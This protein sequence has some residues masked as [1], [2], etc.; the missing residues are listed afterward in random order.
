ME[1][2]VASIA[3]ELELCKRMLVE[4]IRSDIGLIDRIAQHLVLMKGKL[5]RPKL[6]LLSA[7]ACGELDGKAISVA[8]AVELVHTGALIH[9]DV[10]DSSQFRRGM[11]SVN[12]RW[13]DHISVLMGDY[14]FSKAFSMLVDL[15]CQQLLKI[16]SRTTQRMSCGEMLQVELTSNLEVGEGDYLRMI[17]DKTA[18]LISAAC[19]MGAVLGTDRANVREHLARFGENLGYAY[20]I[21]DDL[22]DFVGVE[23]LTG[24][25]VGSDIRGKKITLPLIYALNSAPPTKSNKIK[26]KIRKGVGFDEWK[27]MVD[28]T[29]SYGGTDYA[30]SKAEGFAEAAAKQLDI[31]EGSE[32]KRALLSMVEYTLKRDK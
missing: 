24:K 28:L 22:L 8:T 23:D 12:F 13:N 10:I 32:G 16:F 7:K 2:V 18:S 27:E 1:T 5:F 11:P 25:P 9:D 21:M 29:G 26:E 17:G 15:N 6:A 19:E 30:K 31:L 20:Q 4:S 14:L 3:K